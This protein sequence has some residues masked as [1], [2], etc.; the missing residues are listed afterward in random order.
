MSMF[1]APDMSR[2][3][4]DSLVFWSWIARTHPMFIQ[5]TLRCHN[6]GRRY[7]DE[8]DRFSRRF[9]EIE[10][11]A[12][13]LRRG[14]EGWPEFGGPWDD[15]RDYAMQRPSPEVDREL[16]RLVQEFN[17][18]NERFIEFLDRMAADP[19]ISAQ[20]LVVVMLRHIQSE[21]R[22]M[23]YIF[24]GR[25]RRGLEP[26]PWGWDYE[27]E[28]GGQQFWWRRRRRPWWRPRSWFGFWPWWPVA[29]FGDDEDFFDSQADTDEGGSSE[30][31]EDRS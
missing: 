18:V 23:S 2:Q 31:G 20:R 27:P 14:G 13:R 1:P 25:A 17:S 15:G 12:R 29:P 30:A 10:R 8:L 5:D 9:A 6:I 4:V 7:F 19:E 24:G 22:L 3:V 21:H 11:M 16:A 26:T 28:S